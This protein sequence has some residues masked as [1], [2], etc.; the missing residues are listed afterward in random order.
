MNLIQP[1][2]KAILAF[3]GAFATAFIIQGGSYLLKK[4]GIIETPVDQQQTLTMGL[5]QIIISALTGVGAMTV[6]YL[7]P[8]NK[9]KE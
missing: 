6:T 7:G 3:A 1:Y 9:P 4:N 8:S 2:W 5:E